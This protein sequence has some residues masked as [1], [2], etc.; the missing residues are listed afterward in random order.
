M[1]QEK[2]CSGFVRHVGCLFYFLAS[3]IKNLLVKAVFASYYLK[4]SLPMLLKRFL[5]FAELQPRVS[6]RHVSYKKKTCIVNNIS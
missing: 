4:L 1:I 6:Y 3:L 2:G 5:I